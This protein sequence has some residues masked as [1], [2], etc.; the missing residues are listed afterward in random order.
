MVGK[1]LTW[2]FGSRERLNYVTPSGILFPGK[3]FNR[4][5][6]IEPNVLDESESNTETTSCSGHNVELLKT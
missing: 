3:G 6:S 1:K 5:F 2:T 4:E